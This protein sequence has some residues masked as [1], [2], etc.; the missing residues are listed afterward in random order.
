MFNIWEIN[1]REAPNI[2]TTYYYKG[3][4]ELGRLRD[5][6]IFNSSHYRQCTIKRLSGC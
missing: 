2:S 5:G 4:R 1:E 3:R 6:Q